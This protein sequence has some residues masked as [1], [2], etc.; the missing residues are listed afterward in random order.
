MPVAG[1]LLAACAC[2][3]PAA[4]AATSAR[5]KSVMIRPLSLLKTTDLSF[6]NII[7]APVA[8]SVTINPSTDA[9]VYAGVT[10]AGGP[11]HAA[12]LVG[13]GTAGQLVWVRWTTAPVILARQGGGAQM[14]M[15]DLRTNS[16]LFVFAGSDPRIIP[17]DRVLDIRFGGRL[18]VG[19]NQREGVYEGSFV[20]TIDYP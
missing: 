1:L 18:Q 2:A 20:V 12:R 4:A 14:T 17:A 9:P 11:I 10:G 19:A 8:G 7:A 15:T 16:V 6:G 13:A 3:V 5:A